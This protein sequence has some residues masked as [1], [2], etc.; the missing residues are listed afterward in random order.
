MELHGRR[1]PDAGASGPPHD[2]ARHGA[3]LGRQDRHPDP[4]EKQEHPRVILPCPYLHIFS[5]SA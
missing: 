5:L 1:L 4:G 2:Q 3:V